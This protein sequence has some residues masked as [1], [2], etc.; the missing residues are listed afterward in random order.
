M[1]KDGWQGLRNHWK[2]EFFSAF[3]VFTLS[4]PF[5]ISLAFAAHLPITSGLISAIVGGVLITFFGGSHL[6][7][8]SPTL[9]MVPLMIVA[10][11]TLGSGYLATGY[12]FV[13]AVV[14]VAGILQILLGLTKI[15]EWLSTIP[16]VIIYGVLAHIGVIIFTYQ[17]H[18]LIGA[19]PST[20][21]PLWALLEFPSNFIYQLKPNIA[22]IG[23]TS[24]ILLFIF[25]SFKYRLTSI[26]SGSLLVLGWGLLMSFYFDVRSNE[27]EAYLLE[28]SRNQ[29]DWFTWPDFSRIHTLHSIEF[30]LVI[31]LFG[32]LETILNVKAI[33]AL[34]FYRRKSYLNRELMAV[35]LGNLVCGLLG[36]MPLISTILHSSINVNTGAKTRWSN[37]ING[38]FLILFMLFLVKLIRYI[39]VASV[40][41]I[42]LYFGYSLASP[43]L[44]KDIQ[45]TGKDQLL[46]FM[47]TLLSSLGGGILVGLCA[48]YV[49]YLLIFLWINRDFKSLFRSTVKIVNYGNQRSKVMV[50]SVAVASNYLHLKR[51]IDQISEGSQIYLDFT[52]SQIVDH[53]FLELVYH[54]PY[55]YNTTEGSIELQGLEDHDVVSDHP[56]STRL[57][58]SKK[59][60][61]KRRLQTD[62]NQYNE[63][64]LDVLAVAAV[65]N[66]KLRPNLTYDGHKLQGFSFSLGYE[67]KY[68]ENKFSKNFQ[69]L[70]FDKSSKIEFSDIFLSK[71]LRMSEQSLHMSVILISSLQV[72][73]PAFTL[74][75]E[76]I[77]AKVL[78]TIGYEDIDF[79]AHPTFS[80]HYLLKGMDEKE[81][82]AFFRPE[83]IEYLEENRDF[84]IESMDNQ[85]LV[86][87]DMRLMTQVEI[88][89]AMYFVEGLLKIIYQE[90]PETLEM[91]MDD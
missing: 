36:G 51:Q 6:T 4:L 63:R 89:D 10:V 87:R 19:E 8:K 73:V 25:A 85:L 79:R 32:S 86:Y 47:I 24:L 71:G 64:Q 61:R 56:L 15:G 38:I 40:A 81:I 90:T 2:S 22:F 77:L 60:Q 49:S 18:Y 50:R 7:I 48:G 35:G 55:N 78:Q 66:S 44:F 69:P 16:E 12:K 41:A 59:K 28:L 46:I 58:P 68:R 45:H 65:N 30:I 13:F 43:K 70:A 74:S 76:G 14:A 5:A 1:P 20:T 23:I 33:D 39:P 29:A 52:K 62:A 88:E 31:A 57:L 17:I 67:I 83:L 72:Y 82:R 21:E 54:H 3:F 11:Q 53:S 84:N 80:E 37:F 27:G 75:K 91:I 42:V 34:D 26:L 9:A